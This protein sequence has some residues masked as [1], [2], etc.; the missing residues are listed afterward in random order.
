MCLVS[1]YAAEPIFVAS[2]L[3][4]T[5]YFV[6]VTVLLRFGACGKMIAAKRRAKRLAQKG[7]LVGEARSRFYQKCV[8]KLPP[9]VRAAYA[10]FREG[11]TEATEL[12]AA[13]QRSLKLRG[14]L[15]KGGMLGV[16]AVAVISVFLTFYFAVPL[17]ECLL[18]AAVCGFFAAVNG[19]ALRFFLYAYFSSAEKAAEAFAAIADRC[20]LREKGGGAPPLSFAIPPRERTEEL[21]NQKDE[22]TL[23]TLRAFLR[24]LDAK[25]EMK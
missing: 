22:E 12:A 21:N 5:L 10:L 11:R 19:V 8:K 3:L 20:V 25:E 14:E 9:S 15:L 23:L 7:V 4:P 6:A 17:G 1:H 18:R 16:G 24:D 2:C 13:A